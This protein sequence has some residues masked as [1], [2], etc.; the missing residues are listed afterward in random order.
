MVKP[1]QNELETLAV[2]TRFTKNEIYKYY[3]AVASS[4]LDRAAFDATLRSIFR[5]DSKVLAER[6]W[7]VRPSAAAA[8]PGPAPPPL[9]PAA[10]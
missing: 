4:S 5:I 6:L 7:C 8:R 3:G 10:P 9:R 2:H 1:S